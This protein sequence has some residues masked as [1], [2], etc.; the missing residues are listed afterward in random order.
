[1]TPLKSLLLSMAALRLAM[2]FRLPA[3]KGFRDEEIVRP[4]DSGDVAA[5]PR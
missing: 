2:C 5:I 4:N 3:S 1:M